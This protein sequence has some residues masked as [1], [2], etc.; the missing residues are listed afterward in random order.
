MCCPRPGAREHCRAHAAEHF[1]EHQPYHRLEK[2]LERVGV[3]LPRVCQ[4]SLMVQLNERMQPLVTAIQA[5]VFG[6]V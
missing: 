5:Q 3:D 6:S 1:C 2:H 4:V